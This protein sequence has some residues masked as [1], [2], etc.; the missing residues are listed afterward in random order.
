MRHAQTLPLSS[1]VPLVI[2]A[3][4]SVCGEVALRSA[5]TAESESCSG[6]ILAFALD[7]WTAAD[8]LGNASAWVRESGEGAGAALG[9]GST[10]PGAS[11]APFEM[12]I[13]HIPRASATH[14]KG[15]G[16]SSRDIL[17]MLT[18]SVSL[19]S[20]SEGTAMVH[21]MSKDFQL[22]KRVKGSGL[23]PVSRRRAV[24]WRAR[25]AYALTLFRAP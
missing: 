18:R 24:L 20:G 1:L 4:G 21:G 2:A 11:F 8:F 13:L 3:F 15:L 17:S 16:L 7:P 9:A 5:A 19:E 23:L 22:A 25:S 6:S 14:F 12:G 10:H